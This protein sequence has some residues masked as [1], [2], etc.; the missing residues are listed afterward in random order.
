[1]RSLL[2]TDLR[3]I[4]KDKLFLV[5]CILGTVLASFTPL[6]YKGLSLII[7]VEDELLGL[8]TDSKDM[9]FSAFE[10]GS[11]FGFILPILLALVLC[12]DFGYGTVRNKIICGKSR[13]KIFLSLFFSGTIV[14]CAMIL[15]HALLTLGIAMC[16]FPYQ[17]EAF[18]ANSFGYM[19]LSLLFSILVYVFIS[20]YVSFLCVSMKNAELA[21]IIYVATNL[22][23]K[24]VGGIVSAAALIGPSFTNFPSE[25]F[26]ILEKINLFNATYIG[27]GTTYSLTDVLCLVIA[28][29]VGIGLSIFLGI[30]VFR[31]KDIK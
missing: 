25:L 17:A 1:M 22:F 12:K 2:K 23:F 14:M 13:T 3:R 29:L 15:A 18:D 30:T 26:V 21:V 5:V 16:F 7:G 11:T 31:K 8:F 10:P 4:F 20:A 19:M 9:F 24:I 28:S 27:R 6:L